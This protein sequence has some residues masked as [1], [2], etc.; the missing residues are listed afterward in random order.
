MEEILKVEKL[1]MTI[2]DSVILED[3]SFSIKK[4]EILAIVGESGS[5]KTMT[6]LVTMGLEPKEAVVS[7]SVRLNGRELIG[8][9]N[10]KRRDINGKEISMIFQEP[11]TSLNP[12]MKVGKQVEEMLTLH[13]DMK[14]ADRKE[15]VINMFREVELPNPE[16]VYN[17]YPFNLSGGMRQRVMIAMALILSPSLMIADE[18]TTALDREVEEEIIELLL[19]LNK[20]K[21]VS[22]IFVSHDLNIVKEI[23][24]N[25]MV[26]RHGNLIEYGRTIDIFEN[27]SHDYTKTLIASICKDEKVSGKM[28]NENVLEVKNVSLYYDDRGEKE[29]IAKNLSFSIKGGEILGIQG[30][31]GCGKTTLVKAILGLHGGYD[32]EIICREEKRHMVFQDPYGALNPVKKIGWS[33]REPLVIANKKAG[34]RLYTNEEIDKKV[35]DMIEKV[36][37]SEKHLNRYPNQLSGGQRQRVAIAIALIGG[38]RFLVAD[39]PVSA[40][41]VTIQKQILTLLLSLQKELGL[42]ILFISHDEF[43]MKNICDKI[44]KW[45]DLY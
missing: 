7:G 6:S 9:D 28:D 22:I 31:S 3:V 43:V 37:L 11:M 24:H 32:G 4:G 42:T 39:E 13:T 19:R 41:D 33:L 38:S 44:V 8:I 23:S 34:G 10:K 18:P 30:K 20:E 36:G 14:K 1:N 2:N 16:K 29:Y 15:A 21:N 17:L 5:G 40:L 27:P 12:L 25:V 26:M 45:D 35:L